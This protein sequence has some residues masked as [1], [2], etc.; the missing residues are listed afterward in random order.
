[1]GF[2]WAEAAFSGVAHPRVD[3]ALDARGPARLPPHRRVSV[4]PV[5]RRPGQAHLRPDRRGRRALFPEIEFVKALYL[6]DHPLVLDAFRERVGEVDG[7]SPAMNCQLCKYRTQI[8]GYEEDAGAPQ[9]AHH[10]HVRGHRHR[11][12]IIHD[13]HHR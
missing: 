8:V 11:P 3:A 5:H 12:V 6:R 1:M 2:G 7:A 10:H 4:F 9:T 13:H